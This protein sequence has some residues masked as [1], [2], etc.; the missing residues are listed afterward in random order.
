MNAEELQ[1]IMDEGFDFWLGQLIQTTKI[2]RDIIFRDGD[3][4]LAKKYMEIVY[5]DMDILK[6][7]L[8]KEISDKE[9]EV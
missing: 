8:N 4:K 2:T 5:Q 7:I 3:T 1:K 6:N 9:K